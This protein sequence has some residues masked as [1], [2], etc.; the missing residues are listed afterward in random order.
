MIAILGDHHIWENEGTEQY[1]P[2]DAIYWHENYDYTTLDYDIML[3]KLAHPV[4]KNQYVKPVALPDSCPTA[5]D[6]CTVS[7]W[8]NI[9]T[10]EGEAAEVMI[11]YILVNGYLSER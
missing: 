6:M 11:Q 2:V 1:M 9:Y 8:G 3:L 10:D 5:G 4:T 7:G